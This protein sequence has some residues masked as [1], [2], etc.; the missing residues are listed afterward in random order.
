MKACIVCG[1][2]TDRHIACALW[3]FR[4]VEWNQ[5]QYWR[6]N[7]KTFGLWTG[8]KSNLTLSFPILN[9]LWNWKYRKMR[10]HIPK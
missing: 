4:L 7:I 9:T 1:E 2:M 8:L 6:G 10:L 5:W 3:H